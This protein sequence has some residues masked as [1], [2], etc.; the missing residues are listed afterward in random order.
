MKI[1][2]I[3]LEV[4]KSGKDYLSAIFH[5]K[6]DV[7][8]EKDEIYTDGYNDF[9]AIE[10]NEIILKQLKIDKFYIPKKLIKK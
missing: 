6:V 7:K 4:V 9:I 5:G 3:E 1:D 8:L 10:E 2:I